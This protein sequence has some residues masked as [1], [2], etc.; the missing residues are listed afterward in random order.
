MPG[1][2]V[3]YA[4]SNRFRQVNFAAMLLPTCKAETEAF[5]ASESLNASR[6]QINERWGSLSGTFVDGNKEMYH[7]DEIEQP[8]EEDLSLLSIAGS[9][10]FF[11]ELLKL[12]IY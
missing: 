4:V 12:F 2:I 9:L 3:A 5:R 1:S 6:I 7:A 8:P 11:L 10:E